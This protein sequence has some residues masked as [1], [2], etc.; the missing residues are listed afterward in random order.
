MKRNIAIIWGVS[1]LM[2]MTSCVGEQEDIFDESSALR[3]EHAVSNYNDLLCS[4][5][6]G[7]VMQYFARSSECGYPMLVKFSKSGAVEIAAKNKYSSNNVYAQESSLFEIISDNGPVLTFNSYNNLLHIF[8]TPED[9]PDT[10]NKEEGLGHE[11]DYEFVL[12][13]VSEDQN[14]IYMKGK[15]Y[16][17]DILLYRLPE[18]QGWEDYFTQLEAVRDELFN[19]KVTTLYMTTDKGDFTITGMSTG[20]FDFVPKG[21][22]AI[23]ETVSVGYILTT[24]KKVSLAV[25]FTGNDNI[26]S[27]RN[28]TLS[29]EGILVCTDDGGENAQISAGGE[30]NMVTNTDYK[31]RMDKNSLE[32]A[33]VDAYANV[34]SGTRAYKSNTTFQYFELSYDASAQKYSLYF[35]TT[36]YSGRI[37]L[38][39]VTEGNTVQFTYNGECDSNGSVFMRDV[40]AYR[41]FVDLLTSM[42]YTMV[43]NSPLAMVEISMHSVETPENGFVI[44]LQ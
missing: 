9:I 40:E 3:L 6:N 35:K 26:F 2:L 34:V 1:A 37:Y 44:A 21:G 39:V 8:S 22:D 43:G 16:G 32:G 36:R 10:D 7:W 30:A 31:W 27:I 19:S 25:P 20:M 28:F 17:L 33:F 5:T 12:Y 42:K 24:D 18:T 41:T 29:E 23:S 13:S 14:T 4:A 38:D 11:G 15:K